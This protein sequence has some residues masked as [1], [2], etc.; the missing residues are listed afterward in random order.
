MLIERICQA[1]NAKAES[2]K[3]Q[4]VFQ[5]TELTMGL[6]E[7]QDLEEDEV[8]VVMRKLQSIWRLPLGHRCGM[9]RG[10]L[11]LAPW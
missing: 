5:D 8:F 3:N 4:N 10:F 1:Q 2:S 11:V 9:M 6:Q 7:T